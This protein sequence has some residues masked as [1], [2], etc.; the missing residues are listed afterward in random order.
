VRIQNLA[1]ISPPCSRHPAPPPTSPQYPENLNPFHILNPYFCEIYF[2]ITFN[3][4][5]ISSVIPP[6][7]VFRAS[8]SMEQNPTKKMSVVKKFSA[9]CGTLAV[10]YKSTITHHW[11]LPSAYYPTLLRIY[12]IAFLPSTPSSSEWSVLYACFN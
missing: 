6:L 5:L 7:H 12:N 2:N 1:L 11:A 8:L 3:L 10:V 4:D 9:L